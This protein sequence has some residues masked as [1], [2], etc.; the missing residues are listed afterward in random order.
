M[1]GCV[2]PC[3]CI[4]LA[5]PAACPR[6]LPPSFFFTVLFLRAIFPSLFAAAESHSVQR[7][8]HFSGRVRERLVFSRMLLDPVDLPNVV[9]GYKFISCNISRNDRPVAFYNKRGANCGA[10]SFI[11]GSPHLSLSPSLVS[12]LGPAEART[13]QAIANADRALTKVRNLRST[14]QG[15]LE[16]GPVHDPARPEDHKVFFCLLTLSSE[17]SASIWHH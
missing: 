2:A 12:F 16:G 17:G 6:L 1:W 10:S 7:G 9:E 14:R 13:K 5:R 15:G 4:N 11:G 3:G 8:L